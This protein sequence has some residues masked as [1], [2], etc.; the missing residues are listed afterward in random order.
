MVPPQNVPWFCAECKNPRQSSKCNPDS[1]EV[2]SE[3]GLRRQLRT[4]GA[5]LLPSR[6]RIFHSSS[7]NLVK[8]RYKKRMKGAASATAAIGPTAALPVRN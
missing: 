6:K 2:P 4:Q 5:P 3:F 8:R 1:A 7:Q